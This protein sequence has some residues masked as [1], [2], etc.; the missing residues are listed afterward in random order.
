ELPDAVTRTTF[1]AFDGLIVTATS[2][3]QDEQQWVRLDASAAPEE[4]VPDENAE[5]T[6]EGA[7]DAS[8]GGDA[9]AEAEQINA[10]VDGWQ[11]QIPSYMY[12]Q[13]TRRMDDLLAAEDETED[14]AEERR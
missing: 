4:S 13:L 6:P 8:A 14:G 2:F 5:S 9:S 12:G 7:A 1:R 3:E 11:Y 10:R